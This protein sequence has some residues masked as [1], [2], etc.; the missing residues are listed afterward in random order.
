MAR[1][2]RRYTETVVL[3]ELLAKRGMV[4]QRELTEPVITSIVSEERS[5]QMRCERE[6]KKS[7][8]KRDRNEKKRDEKRERDMGELRR[9]R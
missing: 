5:R 1:V 8:E 9:A 4:K 3:T 2:L 6:E 7:D